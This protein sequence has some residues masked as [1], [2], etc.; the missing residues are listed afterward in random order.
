MEFTPWLLSTITLIAYTGLLSFYLFRKT[1][2]HEEELD[3]L[4]KD[5]K[6]QLIKH[7]QEAH[8]QANI[9]VKRAFQLIEQ[10]QHISE[11]L[12]GHVQAEYNK[13]L[14]EAKDAKKEILKNARIKAEEIIKKADE[15]LEEYKA[16]R[17]AEIEKNLVKLIV[18]VSEKVV[19]KALDHTNHIKLIQEALEDVKKRQER[20]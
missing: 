5:S 9:K 19:G 14:D 20:A 10:L 3:K 4:L 8:S 17:R 2:K 16:E 13:I 11:D 6:Q 18:S 7:K 12:E 1:K 15:E